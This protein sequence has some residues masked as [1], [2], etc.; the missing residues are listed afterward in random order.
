[1]L[2]GDPKVFQYGAT[3]DRISISTVKEETTFILLNYHTD[4][5]ESQ[6]KGEIPV[7]TKYTFDITQD[8]FPSV[9]VDETTCTYDNGEYRT[10]FGSS[11]YFKIAGADDLPEHLSELENDMNFITSEAL[12][13][14]ESN[15][16]NLKEQIRNLQAT[17]FEVVDELPTSDIKTNIIYLVPAQSSGIDNVYD[18]YIY[19]N[20]NWEKIGTTALDLIAICH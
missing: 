15:I 2:P 4:I 14:L 11:R 18:E 8:S 6:S 10:G 20:N 16:E 3:E 12:N 13:P 7:L 5:K 9:Y 1:M 19:A 17:S